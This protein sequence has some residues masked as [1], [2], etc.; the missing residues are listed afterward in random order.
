MTLEAEAGIE[1]TYGD[2]QSPA[3]PLCHSAVLG[4]WETVRVS[5][6]HAAN[7]FRADRVTG[8]SAKEALYRWPA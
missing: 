2:L 4:P 7:L 8:P 6:P 3:W 5:G 1:P